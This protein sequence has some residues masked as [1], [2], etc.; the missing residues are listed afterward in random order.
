MADRLLLVTS[1]LLTGADVVAVQRRLALLGF[2]PGAADGRYGTATER[3][4][5]A[6]Q[7]AAGLTA[8]SIV[9][10]QTR[11]AFEAARPAPPPAPAS[12]GR[13][14]LAEARRWLGTT[15]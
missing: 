12:P 7:A 11:Q 14:A 2:A 5:R 4:V 13:R 3:A 9:E 6:F 10:P 15:E 8:D 1:P